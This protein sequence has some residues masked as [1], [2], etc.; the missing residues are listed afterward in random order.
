[1][2]GNIK[3]DIHR[4]HCKLTKCMLKTSKT[5]RVGEKR[6]KDQEIKRDH[7]IIFWNKKRP[8]Y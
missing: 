4:L 2:T 6:D 1:M 5:L 8:K 3:D 7:W